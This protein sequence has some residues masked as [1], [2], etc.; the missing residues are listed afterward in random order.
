MVNKGAKSNFSTTEN[1]YR[2]GVR[3]VQDYAVLSG[4]Y[5]TKSAADIQLEYAA[6]IFKNVNDI[7]DAL[8]I[9]NSKIGKDLPA[10]AAKN[11]N[12]NIINNVINDDYNLFKLNNITSYTKIDKDDNKTQ[13]KISSYSDI[14]K[15]S[16]MNIPLESLEVG[17]DV[18]GILSS[19]YMSKRAAT[20]EQIGLGR[21]D[22]YMS[23]YPNLPQKYSSLYKRTDKLLANDVYK[24]VD[25]VL[26]GYDNL[27]STE[28][29]KNEE[30][31]TDFGKYAIN[32]IAKDLVKYALIKSLDEK[33]NITVENDGTL[34]FD[35]IDRSRLNLKALNIKGVTPEHEA[36]ILL[37]R[38]ETGLSKLSSKQGEIN[39]LISAT[40][41][42]FK[43]LNEN[44]FKL[45]DMI[46][47]RTESG[48]GLR[49]DAAKDIAAVDSVRD[50]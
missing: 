7:N 3:E 33:A 42:R 22:I 13:G 46:I 31:T 49:V 26:S 29:I 23:D 14:L 16:I 11:V 2:Q 44:S 6:N 39:K 48:I 17:D 24:F 47:D 35:N 21:F 41:K 32:A 30:D 18:L 8:R 10:I 15:K 37:K 43:G 12:K 27:S 28:K 4:S 34:N 50:V 25:K 40:A 9:F 19:G 5:W 20:N 36:A 1:N 45:A 38:M